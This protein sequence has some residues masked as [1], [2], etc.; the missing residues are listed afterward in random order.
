MFALAA[1]ATVDE[2]RGTSWLGE[3]LAELGIGAIVGTAI[4]FAGGWLLRWARDPGWVAE[5]FAGIAVLALALL[6]YTAVL[7]V[8]GN[9]FVAAFYA[10]LAF[11]ASAGRRGPTELVFLEQLTSLLVWLAFGALVIPVVANAVDLVVALYA[12][13]SLTLLR[14]V[15]VALACIGAG[16]DRNT[17][18]FVGWFGPRGLASLVFAL[19]ALEQLGTAAYR[20]VTIIGGT[21]LL[22]VVAHG[23][24]AAPLATGYGSAAQRKGAGAPGPG[25][26][27]AT[28]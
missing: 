9:G 15:P 21:V 4:G 7:R 27:P 10:G 24:K 3:A 17:V 12:I 25:D 14:M 16:L 23:L 8:H 2:M 19:L 28:P 13:L 6:A 20:A 22:S 1:A 11:G 26:V 5:N 18:V